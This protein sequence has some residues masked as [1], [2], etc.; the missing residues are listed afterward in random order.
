MDL[1]GHF[2]K[3]IQMSNKDI[4]KYST[5]LASREMKIKT[6]VRYQFIFIKMDIIKKRK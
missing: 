2:F 1:N 4:K 5:S 3:D 6:T